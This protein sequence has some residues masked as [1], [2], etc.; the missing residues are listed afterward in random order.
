MSLE[1]FDRNMSPASSTWRKNGFSR[2]ISPEPSLFTVQ[3]GQVTTTGIVVRG[4]SGSTSRSAVLFLYRKNGPSTHFVLT[5]PIFVAAAIDYTIIAGK[6]HGDLATR[7]ANDIKSERRVALGLDP[8]LLSAAALSIK[9]MIETKRRRVHE[10]GTVI[11]GRPAFKEYMAGLRRGWT[12]SLERVEE[13]ERLSRELETDGHFDEPEVSPGS[14]S[15]DFT[16][17]E[18]IPTPSRLPPSRPAGLY[19]PLSTVNRP[20]A[21]PPSPS[22]QRTRDPAPMCLPQHPFRPNPAPPRPLRQPRRNQ[23][24]PPHALGLLQRATQSPRWR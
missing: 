8:P 15:D 16:D 5:Q 19:S 12:E 9:G 7:V 14:S 6:R 1:K 4:I 22:A 17:A 18:P 23:A 10:G 3:N 24:R 13:D 20:P 21:G 2:L 11:V